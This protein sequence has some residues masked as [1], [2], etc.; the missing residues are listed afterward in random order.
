MDFS[1]Q[2][3]MIHPLCLCNEA[4]TKPQK[5][6]AEENLE[7]GEQAEIWGE[8][9]VQGMEALHPFPRPCPSHLF[10]LTVPELYPII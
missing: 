5:D 6:G 7:V 9:C 8:W 2:G 10:H 3:P 4:S 1:H